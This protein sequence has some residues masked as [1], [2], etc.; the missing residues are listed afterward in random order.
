MSATATKQKLLKQASVLFQKWGE[1]NGANVML[2][3]YN[4]QLYID[5]DLV[6]MYWGIGGWKPRGDLDAR[7]EA[8]NLF[9]EPYTSSIFNVSELR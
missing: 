3:V 2:R 7:L 1:D 4:N 6:D 5:G 9:V 8:A